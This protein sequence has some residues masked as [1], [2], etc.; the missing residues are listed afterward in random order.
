MCRYQNTIDYI[1]QEE[2]I[3]K[4]KNKMIVKV[5]YGGQ[6]YKNNI[7][8]KIQLKKNEADKKIT[9]FYKL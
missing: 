4:I 5:K 8:S 1:S 6:A 2:K 3:I 7:N 9:F